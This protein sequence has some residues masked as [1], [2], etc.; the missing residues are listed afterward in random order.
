MVPIPQD[1]EGNRIMPY[2]E[3]SREDWGDWDW[4]KEYFD[5]GPLTM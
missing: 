3:S 1:L 2:V 5:T 4:T